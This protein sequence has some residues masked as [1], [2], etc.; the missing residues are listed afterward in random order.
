MTDYHDDQLVDILNY[1]WPVDYT[2]NRTPT[3][4]LNNLREPVDYS[5]H[6]DKYI[7]TEHKHNAL[8]GPFTNKH[9]EPWCQFSPIMTRKKKH[10]CDRRIIVDLSFPK[11][12]SVNAGIK[13]GLLFR[14]TI[15]I[16][17]AWN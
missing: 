1:G 9:F 13:K 10:S 12:K 2:Y 4:T 15:N 11:R 7:N 8:L 14:K 6:I 5:V 16:H 3:P 17:T